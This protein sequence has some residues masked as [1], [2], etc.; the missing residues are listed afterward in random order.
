MQILVHANEAVI[1]EGYEIQVKMHL[2]DLK[3]NCKKGFSDC[4]KAKMYG[5]W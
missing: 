5:K 1:V 3:W 4:D 2:T